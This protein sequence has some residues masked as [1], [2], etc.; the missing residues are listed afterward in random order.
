MSTTPILLP[1]LCPRKW[2]CPP[3]CSS[4]LVPFQ[5]VLHTSG[6]VR[7]L[8]M[9]V[10]WYCPAHLQI[11]QWDAMDLITD[12]YSNMVPSLLYA[13]CLM[14]LCPLMSALGPPWF[15]VGSLNEPPSSTCKALPNCRWPE[16]P[17][18]SQSLW[19]SCLCFL[20]FSAQIP[21]PHW[22]FS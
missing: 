9:P 5:P 8:R 4:C 14:I 11:F 1:H 22:S 20:Y 7:F 2:H 12:Q 17:P 10:C 21:L 13:S 15:S 16:K 3:H 19:P 18:P 6:R